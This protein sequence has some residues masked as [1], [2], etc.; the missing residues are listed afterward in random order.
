MMSESNQIFEETYKTVIS[1]I[2]V[3]KRYFSFSYQLYRNG[4]LI[5]DS[6]YD[7]SHSRSPAFM[8]K[9]LRNG[10]ASEIVLERI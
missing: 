7:S 6:T 2:S 10:Y 1:G 8:R 9:A 3:G 5:A 4:K